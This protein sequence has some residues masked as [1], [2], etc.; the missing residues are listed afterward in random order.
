MKSA[1]VLANARSVTSNGGDKPKVA[2]DMTCNHSF[3]KEP[4]TCW[5]GK[6]S[7]IELSEAKILPVPPNSLDPLYRDL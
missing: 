6:D 5:L 3:R 2:Q 4:S 7:E 1:P